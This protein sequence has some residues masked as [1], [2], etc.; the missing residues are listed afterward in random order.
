MPVD[1]LPIHLLVCTCSD[2]DEY[3]EMLRS[4]SF[5]IKRGTPGRE[6]LQ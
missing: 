5:L 6:L 3:N 4:L 1:R 2:D